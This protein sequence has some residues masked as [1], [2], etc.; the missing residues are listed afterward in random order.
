MSDTPKIPIEFTFEDKGFKE[1]SQQMEKLYNDAKKFSD[2][3]KTSGDSSDTARKGIKNTVSEMSKLNKKM[4]DYR[5]QANGMSDSILKMEL[6]MKQYRAAARLAIDP[7]EAQRYNSEIVK[8]R[9]N[10]TKAKNTTGSWG[11]A[12]GSFQFKFNALGN[13]AANVASS[14]TNGITRAIRGAIDTTIEFEKTFAEVLTLLNQAQKADFKNVLKQ[15]SVDIMKKYGL[16]VQDTNKAMFDAIS[17]GVKLS[18]VYEVMDAAARLAVGGV[19]DLNSAT[20]GI[21]SVINAFSLDMEEAENVA[22][23]FF[24]AQRFG[25]TYI[26]DMV[27]SMGRA[28]TIASLTGASYKDMLSAFTA[29]TKSGLNTE[30]S[31]TGLR[32]IFK[33]LVSPSKESADALARFGVAVGADAVKSRGFIGVL[34]DLNEVFKKNAEAIPQIFGNIRGLT[35][36]MGIL[37]ERYDEFK[38]ILEQV[39]DAMA[40]NEALTQAVNEQMGTTAKQLDLLKS[41]WDSF[42]IALTE[43][44][45]EQGSFFKETIKS[46]TT[47]LNLA[48]PKFYEDYREAIEEA[49]LAVDSHIKQIKKE[50]NEKS[51]LFDDIEKSEKI[52]SDGLIRETKK[53]IRATSDA[54]KRNEELYKKDLKQ[55]SETRDRMAEIEDISV[56][57]DYTD[58]LAKEYVG[59]RNALPLLEERVDAE[60]ISLTKMKA[61]YEGLLSFLQK[62]L[63]NERDIQDEQTTLSEQER[64]QQLASLKTEKEIALERVKIANDG[65]TERKK[66]SETALK[67]DLLILEKTNKTD[68]EK[69]K[70]RELLRLKH[71]NAMLEIER[72]SRNEQI[73][74]QAE[75]DELSIENTMAGYEKEVALAKARYKKEL[76]LIEN[77]NKDKD[78]KNKEQESAALEHQIKLTDI[79]Y[80]YVKKRADLE[81][82]L[83]ISRINLE[84]SGRKQK[85]E[86]LE[87]ELDA[88]YK[89]LTA[90]YEAGEIA[91]SEYLTRLEILW[92]NFYAKI[93]ALEYENLGDLFNID[94]KIQKNF[95][96][97]LD[98][99]N[100]FTDAWVAAADER[101]AAIQRE[102]DKSDERFRKLESDRDHEWERQK[103]GYANNY[104]LKQRELEDERK[105][106][107]ELRNEERKALRAK[108]KA[109]TAQLILDRAVAASQ[110]TVAIANLY[111]DLTSSFGAVGVAIATALSAVMIG[112]FAA[113]TVQAAKAVN[114]STEQGFAE[115]VIDLNGNGTEKSDS[116][117][118]RLSK[119]ESVMKAEVTK[120]NKGTLSFMQDNPTHPMFKMLESEGV[121]NVFN[122][123][124]DG[125]GEGWGVIHDVDSGKWD[126]LLYEEMKNHNKEIRERPYS[127][128]ESGKI[129]TV[130]GNQIIISNG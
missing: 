2:I 61:I 95:N 58:E 5:S 63:E 35:G 26:D 19:T 105:R 11:K 93:N 40:S 125:M 54:V 96:Q 27:A 114:S 82:D 86:I 49:N 120:N 90:S 32:N 73:N 53:R 16:T 99:L 75:Y 103:E 66:L 31:I 69:A 57:G 124:S 4:T 85:I 122:R 119:R 51:L 92:N 97:A 14:I 72:S 101:V 46:L 34:D 116:I 59:L 48:T 102:I 56:G 36:V 106:Q 7:K 87:E 67:Y 108:R 50:A 1:L 21:A 45:S 39:N 30:E 115:G 22:S 37:G 130:K 74:L 84:G 43:G 47:L 17:A 42:V 3:L 127:F 118:A 126:E 91:L 129:I 44:G 62:H 81:K 68:E 18:N 13:I 128:R 94:P 20:K 79:E 52:Y 15:N 28:N 33:E 41:S 10:I 71:K 24:Q 117:P 100:E 23:A 8:L 65:F 70:E 6:R 80:K 88:E 55:L 29:I 104:N 78:V 77:S 98:T 76:E 60:K 9:K 83:Q 38:F 110:L 25:I 111:K 113:T 123:L 12:L 89:K 121:N 112:A 107:E 64:K 109:A